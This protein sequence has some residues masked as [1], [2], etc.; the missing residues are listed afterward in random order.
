VKIKPHV[1]IARS[2][3]AFAYVV[4]AP[5]PGQGQDSRVNDA[6]REGASA[7]H[8]GNAGEAESAFRRAVELAP[9]MAEAHLDLGLVLGREGKT[10]EAIASLRQA[11]TLDNN[12]ASAHMFLG[13]FLYQDNHP[14][15]AKQ[16][17]QAELTQNPDSVETLTWLG[18][19]D[20][21][22]SNPDRA[23]VPLDHAAE[24]APND[25]N[26]LELRARAHG[27]VAKDSYAR[28]AKL[29]PGSWH[30]H[31]VQAQLDADEGKHAEAIAEY[32]AAI[33]L[34]PANPDLYEEMGDQYRA[35]SQL[36]AAENAY[37][38]GLALGPANPVALYNLGSTEV[39]R[40]E[41]A[42]GVP[43]LQ[44]ALSSYPGSPVAEYYLGRG[45]ADVGDDE[46]AVLWLK[47]AADAGGA[48]DVTQRAYYELTRVYRKLHRPSDAQAALAQFNQLRIAQ[49]KQGN[50]QVEDWKKLGQAGPA[51]TTPPETP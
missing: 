31:H 41:S 32:Q 25:L 28:M 24:L 18:T 40:G 49:E 47:K 45:L 9:A 14:D 42:Q 23:V 50:Q 8:N 4:T 20:L 33:H 1:W 44:R 19:V 16:E 17:L 11:L 22:E 51:T 13:I 6:F 12:L 5:V 21:S 46:Q 39:E 29:D 2:I 43:L 34:Q 10:G 37:R 36:E 48:R 26:I 15:E 30:V 27:M 35:T 7:M 3:L 38:K